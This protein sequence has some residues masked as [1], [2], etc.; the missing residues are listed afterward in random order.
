[1]IDP[2]S[3]SGSQRE[4]PEPLL[5]RS[6][7]GSHIALRSAGSGEGTPMLV[8]NPV[9]ASLA[10]WREVLPELARQRRWV[11]WDLRGLN[12]SPA[13]TS[14]RP[15]P[16]GHAADAIAALDYLGIDR[17]GIVSW[18]NGSRIALE[19]AARYAERVSALA[20]VN[21]GY[22]Q[23]FDNLV[24]NLE[25]SS[26]LPLLAG[27]VKHF[28]SGAGMA[29]RHLVARPE[30]AGLI[31]QSGMVGTSANTAILIET[32]QAMA[33]CDTGRF[34]AT[35]EAVAGSPA[36][37]LLPKVIA[38]TLLITG[39]RDRFTPRRMVDQMQSSIPNSRVHV[40]ETATHYLPIEYP[41]RLLED[42]DRFFSE[43]DVSAN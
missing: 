28:P 24:R 2:R 43:H 34:L 33:E 40:Y 30:L 36:S 8:V 7:D 4:D 27:V 5:I 21:G 31:R 19:I 14:E 11:S 38:P 20:I 23:S 41:D 37:E 26:A 42:L 9:G 32:L 10:M 29:L 15:D 17:F 25:P 3:E 39:G 12:S 16:A 6:F 1:V 35:F 13:P 18:S 22:G